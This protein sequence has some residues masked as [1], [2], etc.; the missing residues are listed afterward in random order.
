VDI[1]IES[2]EMGTPL[3]AACR[4]GHV[5][6]VRELLKHNQIDVNLES[7]FFEEFEETPLY[8]A[9]REGQVEVVR[10]LLQQKGIIIIGK[11]KN[12]LSKLQTFQSFLLFSKQFH[13][14]Q[15]SAIFPEIFEWM[16]KHMKNRAEENTIRQATKEALKQF[17]TEEGQFVETLGTGSYGVVYSILYHSNLELAARKLLSNFYYE[18]QSSLSKLFQAEF[19]TLE[20][21]PFHPNIVQLIRRTRYTPSKELIHKL[22]PLESGLRDL[23]C[24]ENPR[25]PSLSKPKETIILDMEYLPWNMETF[26]KDFGRFWQNDHVYDFC[27]QLAE[28]V[29]FLYSNNMVHLDLKL[30]NILVS[31]ALQLAICDFSAARHFEGDFKEKLFVDE[32]PGGNTNHLALELFNAPRYVDR[33]TVDYTYQP[34]FALGVLF[35]ELATGILPYKRPYFQS[36]LPG[37]YTLPDMKW[38][39]LESH[40]YDE[41]FVSLIKQLI[42][43]RTPRPLPLQIVESLRQLVQ[44]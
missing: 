3:Y 12:E 36:G 13:A 24:K 35:F 41:R 7:G 8:I 17:S 42:T 31:P 28:G 19:L 34:S 6:I 5:E 10:I 32:K 27:L 21:L 16:S 18:R 22:I 15:L 23:Y 30:E 39:E 14:E 43:A 38:E 44:H 20:Q 11:A 1:N 4:G 25:F 33:K 29:H 40:D 37:N 9:C 2:K 26:M